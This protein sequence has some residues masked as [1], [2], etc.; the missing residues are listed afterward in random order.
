[1]SSLSDSTTVF[2]RSVQTL[3]RQMVCI[4]SVLLTAQTRNANIHQIVPFKVHSRRP[5][6]AHVADILIDCNRLFPSRERV[7]LHRRRYHD[8]E[9]DRDTLTCNRI[10]C[11]SSNASP[12]SPSCD[13]SSQI[14]HLLCHSSS[15]PLSLSLTG[16]SV[17]SLAIIFWCGYGWNDRGDQLNRKSELV[18]V[19]NGRDRTNV[20]ASLPPV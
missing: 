12:S 17:P 13:A 2:V 18:L 9:D 7:M 3:L 8:S 11:H 15:Q 1:M 6:R 10:P 20:A 14:L 16:S 5:L 19:S 4:F